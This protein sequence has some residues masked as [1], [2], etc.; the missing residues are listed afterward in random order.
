MPTLTKTVPGRIPGSDKREW[1]IPKMSGINVMDFPFRVGMVDLDPI[2]AVV[3]P[4]LKQK[5]T[6]I[7]AGGCFGVW[8]VHFAG[9]FQSV[10]TFEPEPVNYKCLVQ[11]TAHLTNVRCLNAALWS[12]ATERVGLCLDRK[13][14]N[15]SGAYFVAGVGKIP[16]ATIDDLNV[17]DCDLLALDI[18]GAEYPA[19]LGG[20][21]TIKR[22]RPVVVL[23]DKGHDAR[24]KRGSPIELLCCEFGYRE[25]D[26]PTPWDIVLV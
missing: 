15:N 18:E 11:N 19:I 10:I 26:R 20:A 6:C 22:C 13:M 23:E 21:E 17:T 16:T 2:M 5:R 9:M 7:Q 14:H 24:F 25:V 8:P 1:R 12:N 4:L 3:D